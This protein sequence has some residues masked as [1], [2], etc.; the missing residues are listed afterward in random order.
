MLIS[1]QRYTSC[2]F[3]SMK[4]GQSSKNP[5]K[6][7]VVDE[8]TLQKAIFRKKNIISLT[9]F[10]FINSFIYLWKQQLV[11]EPEL[12][13]Q[14]IYKFPAPFLFDRSDHIQT[15]VLSYKL[16]QMQWL[17]V[18]RKKFSYEVKFALQTYSIHSQIAKMII[19]AYKSFPSLA[20]PTKIKAGT[21]RNKPNTAEFLV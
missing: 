20:R 18:F 8:P 15:P 21:I 3:C 10:R 7:Y 11:R 14:V 17:Q 16:R 12:R 9:D 19:P 2:S 1:S 6:M 4:A 5:P 13:H